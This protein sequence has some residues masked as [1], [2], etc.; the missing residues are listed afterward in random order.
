MQEGLHSFIS[1]VVTI[2]YSVRR[3]KDSFWYQILIFDK[4]IG[5]ALVQTNVQDFQ[6]TVI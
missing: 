4:C 1:Q 3:A 6:L 5:L 2:F